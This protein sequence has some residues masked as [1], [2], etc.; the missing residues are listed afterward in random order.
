MSAE[1]RRQTNVIQTPCALTRKARMSAAVLKDFR[2]ME[3]HVKV[4]EYSYD[5]QHDILNLMA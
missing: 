3:V 1:L 2:V 4:S 5:N